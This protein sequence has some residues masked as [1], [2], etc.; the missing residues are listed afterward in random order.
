VIVLWTPRYFINGYLPSIWTI[1]ES[2][3]GFA[4]DKPVHIFYEQGIS[5]EGPLKVLGKVLVEFNRFY[6]CS[7]EEHERL[8]AW[9][10]WIKEDMERTKTEDSRRNLGNAIW[11]GIGAVSLFALGFVAGKTVNSKKTV[12]CH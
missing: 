10:Q 12:G 5:L 1:L 2:V 4:K 3:V 9:A 11:V 7:Q 8:Y 6:F